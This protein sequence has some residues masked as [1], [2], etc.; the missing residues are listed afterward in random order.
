MQRQGK[1]KNFSREFKLEAVRRSNDPTKTIAE[2]ARELDI[3]EN[4]LHEWR[5]QV[6]KKGTNVFPGGGRRTP[7]S[8]DNE[9]LQLKK[10]NARLREERD[11]L[12]KSLIYFAKDQGESSNL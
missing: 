1:R 7:N 3:R 11:I 2:V 4:D 5:Y 12:K 10:E 6:S 9:L 8:N